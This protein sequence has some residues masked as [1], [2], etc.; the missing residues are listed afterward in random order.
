MCP[1]YVRVGW[2]GLVLVKLL[3]AHRQLQVCLRDPTARRSQ[4]SHTTPYGR[5]D[6]A[7]PFSKG[8]TV[9]SS[10]EKGTRVW[11]RLSP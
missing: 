3:G 5:E 1:V 2:K 9:T 10:K 8:Q 6:K 7:L 4:A 11:F